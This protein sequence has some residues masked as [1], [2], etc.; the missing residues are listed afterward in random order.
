[1]LGLS[2]EWVGSEAGES[3]VEVSFGD[4]WLYERSLILIL[5]LGFSAPKAGALGEVLLSQSGPFPNGDVPTD[6]FPTVD[7]LAVVTD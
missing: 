6:D 5:I 4:C 7:V 1:M 2:C 3:A